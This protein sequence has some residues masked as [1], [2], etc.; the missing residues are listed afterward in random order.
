MNDQAKNRKGI[1]L[2]TQILIG[3]MLGFFAG[4]FLG[5]KASALA[6]VGRAYIGLIQ[7][8]ILPY[9][10]VSLMLGIGSLSYEKAGKLAITGGI[11]LVASWFLA[12]AIVFLMPLAFPS[13]K[14]GSFFSTSLV[15]VAKVDFIDLYIP[16]NPFSSMARTVVPAAAVFSVAFGIALIGVENKQSLLDILTATSKTLTRIAM[17]VVKVTPIGVFAIAANAAGTMTIEEFGRLQSYIIPFI[18]AT[19]LLT[20]WILPGLAAALTPF[21]YREIL[22]SARDALTTGFVTGNLFITLPMLVENARKL[23]EDRRIKSKD[24][25]NYVEVL[26]PTSFNFPNIGKLLTL[27]FVL[28]AGWFVGKSIA[29]TDYPGFAVLGLF[30]LFGGV[31][32]ALPFLLDQMQIPSDM[33]QLY[34][35]T[36]VVNSWFATLLAVMNLFAFTLVAACA[37]TGAVRINWSRIFS[38]AIISLVIFAA[39]LLGTRFMLSEMVSKE[40]LQRRTLMHS[41]IKDLHKADI[42]ETGSKE[43]IGPK[44]PLKSIIKRGKLRVG[45]NPENLP[46]SFINDKG[47][48][49]G[50]D[51]EL[52]HVLARGLKVEIEFIEWT[53]KTVL[54]DLNQGKFDI[55]IGGLI[56]NPERLARVNFSNPYMNMTTALVVEDHRRNKFKSWRAI[57]KKLNARVG[58]VGERRAKNV[59]RYLPNTEI[60]LLETYSDFFT[61]NPKGVDALVISAEAGSAWTILYPAYSVVVPEPH[62]KANAA[63]AIP[64][65]TLDFED[66]VNDWLQMNQTSG[67][68]DKLYNKWILG[69]KVEQK[70]PRWSIGRDVFGLWE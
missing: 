40:D 46:F 8:S 13:I 60:V 34:V 23:F 35:V 52:M 44:N 18:V 29:L 7:M 58:V 69:T 14:G 45:Y 53:Y 21:S 70:K 64:L 17:M 68:I 66:F 2:S 33:Y 65:A 10:V 61:D 50:F 56:V 19:L 20:F 15:E 31:D 49:V 54:K 16:V 63:F 43:A 51:V 57:D 26:V 38:F 67:I 36:G 1:S 42:K 47:D 28:F 5:E 11:V 4:L 9:M 12:F 37:A 24:T 62:L 32:L 59:K 3:L 39:A 41:E 6:I 25:D 48:L 30:T 22:K 27:L 55:A